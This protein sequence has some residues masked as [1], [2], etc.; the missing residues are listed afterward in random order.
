MLSITV[1]A[2]TEIM[3]MHHRLEKKD[4]PT[5]VLLDA[6][7]NGEIALAMTAI[8]HGADV[9]AKNDTG[10]DIADIAF[11]NNHYE[12]ANI[13]ASLLDPSNNNQ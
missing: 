3:G 11:N 5:K 1:I 7:K 12:L 4:N 10:Q 9:H 8:E 6:V 2:A 13:L